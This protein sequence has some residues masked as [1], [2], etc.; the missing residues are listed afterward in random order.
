MSDIKNKMREYLNIDTENGYN[1]NYLRTETNTKNSRNKIE[2][3]FYNTGNEFNSN[4][5]HSSKYSTDSY[6]KNKTNN[7][8]YTQN[9]FSPR[10]NTNILL[11]ETPKSPRTKAFIFNSNMNLN[12][13]STKDFV[14][15]SKLDLYLLN[16][17]KSHNTNNQSNSNLYHYTNDED[18]FPNPSEKAKTYNTNKTTANEKKYSYTEKYSNNKT[19]KVIKEIHQMSKN[20]F[21][22]DSCISPKKNRPVIDLDDKPIDMASYFM[23]SPTH[24]KNIF[25]QPIHFNTEKSSNNFYS[26]SKNQTQQDFKS[27]SKLS[28]IRGSDRADKEKELRHEESAEKYSRGIYNI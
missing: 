28:F 26:N 1:S 13:V 2:Y 18:N 5:A 16:K 15:N 24:R 10:E 9:N 11:T 14:S 27:S 12:M 20:L 19:N 17:P 4:N 3:N 7:N 23:F 21:E 6:R 25:V 22:R 8:F